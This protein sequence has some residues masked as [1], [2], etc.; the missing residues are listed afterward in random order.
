MSKSKR[1]ASSSSFTN[2]LGN[3][4]TSRVSMPRSSSFSADHVSGFAYFSTSRRLGRMMKLFRFTNARA[5][6]RPA[7]ASAPAHRAVCSS[8][9]PGPE[10]LR[11][12]RAEL[13][14]GQERLAFVVEAPAVGVYVVEPYV[15]GATGVS[16]GEQQDSG[17]DTGVRLE[18][19]ARQRDDGVELL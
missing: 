10:R 17:G 18:R 2:S 11:R 12:H 19:T 15:A 16:L 6:H 8:L 3:P 1:L 7:A 9:V 4:A 13:V 14:L 5:P